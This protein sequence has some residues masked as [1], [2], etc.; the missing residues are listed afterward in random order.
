MTNIDIDSPFSNRTAV[1]ALRN[2]VPNGK[3][4]DILGSNQ[5]LAETQFRD[6][7]NS[8]LPEEHWVDNPRSL[9]ISGDFG[10]GKSHLLEYFKH[11][12]LS[13]NYICSMISVS[14]ETPFNKLGT[15]FKSA[16]DEGI[17]PN[18]VGHM[19]NEISILLNYESREYVNFFQWVNNQDE[20]DIHQIFPASVAVN[21]HCPDLEIASKMRNFWAGEKLRQSDIRSGLNMIGQSQNYKF[22]APSQ[23]ILEPQRLRFVLELIKAAGYKGWVVLID[24]FET[25]SSYSILQRAQSYAELSRW[26]GLIPNEVYPGLVTV[27]SISDDY[28]LS[29][30]EEKGDRDKVVP[31]LHAKN[32]DAGAAKARV[33]MA[34]ISE[35]LTL[36]E[37]DETTVNNTMEQIRVLYEKSYGWNT[38]PFESSSQASAGYQRRMRYKIRSAISQWDLKRLFPEINPEIVV[39]E[40]K[41]GY[42]EDKAMEF[43][44]ELIQE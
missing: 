44:E 32:D 39:E 29:V 23:K 8:D 36:D 18:N 37:V 14:K 42:E 33:G 43:T 7:L 3:A 5:P 26:L 40:F 9:M 20:G 41:P 19:I 16:I 28:Q 13:E 11:L 4:V 34:A 10:T 38:P 17:V 1:E 15:V 27:V 12:A 24:E 25:I 31:R 21:E 35:R 6:L 2:G 22:R 30:L